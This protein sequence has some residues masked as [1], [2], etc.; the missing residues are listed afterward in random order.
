[1]RKGFLIGLIF[2]CLFSISLFAQDTDTSK[3]AFIPVKFAGSYSGNFFDY[4][5]DKRSD[6]V[7]I[8][9]LNRRCMFGDSTARG[10][11]ARISECM[12]SFKQDAI[13]MCSGT[14][15]SIVVI[16]SLRISQSNFIGWTGTGNVYGHILILYGDALC[17]K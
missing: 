14:G 2:M 1:M 16:S 9:D 6:L 8:G 13:K 10:V 11:Q 15:A 17:L 5:P 3:K 12:N 4:F 7:L